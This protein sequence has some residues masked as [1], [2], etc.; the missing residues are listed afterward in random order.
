MMTLPGARCFPNTTSAHHWTHSSSES[1]RS[2]GWIAVMFD[3]KAVFAYLRNSPCNLVSLLVSARSSLDPRDARPNPRKKF[4]RSRDR[5]LRKP[6]LSEEAGRSSSLVSRALIDCAPLLCRRIR[7]C[8]S[9]LCSSSTA[10]PDCDRTGEENRPG[11]GALRVVVIA[12][13]TCTASAGTTWRRSTLS[14]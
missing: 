3:G 4:V 10:R 14:K 7:R 11:K 8:L 2:S 6:L 9:R 5:R 1:L 12:G 13:Y